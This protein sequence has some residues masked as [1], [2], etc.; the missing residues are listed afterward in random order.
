M[1]QRR[2]I[3]LNVPLQPNQT[4][5]WAVQTIDTG[6]AKSNWSVEQ[7]YTVPMDSTTP[8]I[9]INS[10]IDY[11]NT[12]STTII[13]N[14][15][16]YDNVNLT[17]V[18]LFGNWGGWHLNETNNSGINNTNYIFTKNL[19]AYGD[20]T[21]SWHIKACDNTSNC[22]NSSIRIF[23]IDTTPPTINLIS[24]T[25]GYTWTS[26][27]TIT[28]TYNVTDVSIRNCSLIINNETVETNTSVIINITQSF[29]RTLSNGN[30]NWS[31]NCTDYAN[32]TNSSVTRSLAVSYTPPTT[33]ET[34]GGGGTITETH[35]FTKIESSMTKTLIKNSIEISFQ[36]KNE[37]R[38]VDI[39]IK[40][41][42]ASPGLPAVQGKVYEYILINRTDSINDSNIQTAKIKF[43]VN[44]SWIIGNNIDQDSITLNRYY[45]NS[46]QKLPTRRISGS[47]SLTGMAVN[48]CGLLGLGC[49]FSKITGFFT[50]INDYIE[51]ESETPGFSYF[52][53]TG[54]EIKP[55]CNPDEKRCSDNK[56]QICNKTWIDLE[57]C[58][59]GCNSTTLACNPKPLEQKECISGTKRCLNN[60]LQECLDDKWITLKTC[61]YRCED[62][63]CSERPAAHDYTWV[64]AGIIASVIVIIC[65]I[66]FRIYSPTVSDNG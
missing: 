63:I 41:L 47:V 60:E 57:S 43:K 13:F 19:S 61:E 35:T 15:T 52:A 23:R 31:I 17:N 48:D 1:M 5:Y 54:E 36:I 51:Y 42:S 40:K 7:N 2:S 59:Y 18:S 21:Y 6:L 53:I 49:L 38:N 25:N 66:R 20:G 62:N 29:T 45:S 37:A 24:P 16:V 44:R 11:Y 10:P 32:Q 12:S 26:S 14:A 64:W 39:N 55:I 4:I 58:E 34:P 9:T 30:Y 46:W 33:P 28:F 27:N 8:T 65:V 22:I 3:T 56:I 50:A